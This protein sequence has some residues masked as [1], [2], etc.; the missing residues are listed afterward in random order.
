MPDE[1]FEFGQRSRIKESGLAPPEKA[2]TDARSSEEGLTSLPVLK[3][4]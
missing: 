3:S 4:L 1:N 2:P